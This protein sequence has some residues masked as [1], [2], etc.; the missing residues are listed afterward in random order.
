[1]PKRYASLGLG[2]AEQ[3]TI[4]DVQ[5]DGAS[6]RDGSRWQ[7]AQRDVLLINLLVPVMIEPAPEEGRAWSCYDVGLLL[8][9]KESRGFDFMLG[10]M[11]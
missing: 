9:Q 1:M 3:H 11:A 2:S 6:R 10:P 4:A 5:P 7:C 8:S